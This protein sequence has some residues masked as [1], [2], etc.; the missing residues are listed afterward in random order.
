M[1]PPVV[2][3]ACL[4][5]LLAGCRGSEPH[6]SGTAGRPEPQIPGDSYK[7][8]KEEL[9]SAVQMAEKGDAEAAYRL[10]LHYLMASNNPAQHRRW[11]EVSA[12]GGHPPAQYSMG[13]FLNMYGKPEEA[14]VWLRMAIESGT[15]AGDQRTV[16]AAEGLL[17]EVDRVLR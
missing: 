6:R 8:T 10:S 7:L 2:L 5:I 11:L 13:Y 3:A 12:K 9:R 15:R 14:R 1:K 16:V 17:A 4:S